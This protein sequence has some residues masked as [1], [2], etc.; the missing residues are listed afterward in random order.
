MEEIRYSFSEYRA[1]DTNVSFDF[2]ENE[3]EMNCARFHDYCKRFAIAIGYLPET[4]EK[5]F[6][7]TCYEDMIDI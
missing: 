6:G 1:D 2:T 4:V 3:D 5:Y 7:E